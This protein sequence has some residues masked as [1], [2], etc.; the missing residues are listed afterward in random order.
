MDVEKVELTEYTRF[1]GCGAKLGPQ[2]LDQVL[3]GLSQPKYPNIIADFKTSDDAGIYK[4]NDTTALVQ[5][6]DFFPPIVD[7]P[8]LFGQIA[9]ANA[10]SDVY[11][12]GGRPV[13]AMSIVCF[14]KDTIHMSHLRAIM[15]GGMSKLV[16]AETALVGGHSIEDAEVKFG[17]SVTGLVDPGRVLLNNKPRIGD[18]LILTKPLGTGVINTALRADEVSTEALDAATKG[19]VTLNKVAAEI[20]IPY[21]LSAC[22]DVTGFGLLGHACEMV[23]DS[24]AGFEIDFSSVP[25]LP[26]VQDYV[27]MGLIPAGTYRNK[28]YRKSNIANYDELS[29]DT[30]DLLFDPQTSGGLLI[31]VDPSQANEMLRQL[32]DEGV[33]AAIVGEVT[34]KAEQIHVTE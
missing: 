23:T 8:F 28:E 17:F 7:D 21:D 20:A 25:L 16:E 29:V 31:A 1:S 13:T 10:L 5:T 3:C 11:A 12:M 33:G 18:Q 32:C 26:S 2:F 30:I 27:A 6:L 24:S 14:P 22:T 34:D 15:D 19:M 9:A 4:I